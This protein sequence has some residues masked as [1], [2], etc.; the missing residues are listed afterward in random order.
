MT[1]L[2]FAKRPVKEETSIAK[3]RHWYAKGHIY[4]VTESVIPG[5]PVVYHALVLD[6]DGVWDRISRHRTLAAAK[7]ACEMHARVG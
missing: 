7:V 5:L 4:R 1:V 2:S 3:R 6:D